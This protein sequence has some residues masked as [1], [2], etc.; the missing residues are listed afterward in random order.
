MTGVKHMKWWGWGVDGIAFHHE[1]KPRL[2][3]F[4]LDKVGLDITTPGRRSLQLEDLTIPPSRLSDQLRATLTKIVGQANV[5]DDDLDRVVHTK[6]KSVRDLIRVRRGE[7]GRVEDVGLQERRERR[8]RPRERHL[9]RIGIRP[10]RVGDGELQCEEMRARPAQRARLRA[11]HL[12]S[13]Q[14]AS[15]RPPLLCHRT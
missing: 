6:G 11:F 3:P 5:V 10:R 9:D 8:Q 2:A 4:V 15:L 7:L 1:D 14:P 13:H 12:T